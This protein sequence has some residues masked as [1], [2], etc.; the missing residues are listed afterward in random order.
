MDRGCSLNIE[1]FPYPFIDADTIRYAL[2]DG[3]GVEAMPAPVLLETSFGRYQAKIEMEPDGTL[4][5]HRRLEITETQCPADGYDAFR[6][7]LRQIAQADHAKVV[8][9]AQ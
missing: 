6:D 9:V 4:A 7:F 2:P 5:Y 8:L 1:Y 3:F